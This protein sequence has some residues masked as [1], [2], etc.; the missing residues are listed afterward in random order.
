MKKDV[1]AGGLEPEQNGGLAPLY[2]FGHGESY[3]TYKYSSL[4]I[5][6]KSTAASK[7]HNATGGNSSLG[8]VSWRQTGDCS[9]TGTRQPASDQC[10]TVIKVGESGFCECSG[11]VKRG[12]VGCKA[13]NS[14]TCTE[15]CVDGSNP[16]FGGAT[17]IAG[18]N[19]TVYVSFSVEN[20]GEV[21][22]T[23]IAQV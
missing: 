12:A 14:F 6:N 1:V 21:A 4:H 5:A 23:E 7:H 20:S 15:V 8:C 19:G 13:S 16:D 9:P 2:I 22:G 3:T 11:G 17:P 18:V 10:G